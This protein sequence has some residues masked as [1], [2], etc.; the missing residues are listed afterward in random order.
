MSENIDFFITRKKSNTFN[1]NPNLISKNND[2][3][4]KSIDV[5]RSLQTKTKEKEKKSSMDYSNDGNS[6]DKIIDFGGEISSSQDKTKEIDLLLLSD[7]DLMDDVEDKI[8]YSDDSRSAMQKL[9]AKL[10]KGSLCRIVINLSILTICISSLNLSQKMIY[11][12]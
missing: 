9:I 7:P 12:Y 10:D 11:Q 1:F 8:I 5:S 4:K 2:Q 6:K 3:L